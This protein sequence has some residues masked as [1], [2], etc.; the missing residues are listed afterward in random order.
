MKNSGLNESDRVALCQKKHANPG[1]TQTD[2]ANWVKDTL[3]KKIT[4]ATVSNTLKRSAEILAPD[5]VIDAKR[6]RQRKVQ[7]PELEERLIEWVLT[8][9]QTGQLTGDILKVKAEQI[10][11]RLY[12]GESTLKFSAGWLEKFK[13]RHGIRQYVAHGESGS[14]LATAKQLQPMTDFYLPN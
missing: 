2:L 13:R 9:Q 6:Q 8:Y 3:G 14:V 5:T 12:P 11:A 7:Y 10:A 1:M 4:Q